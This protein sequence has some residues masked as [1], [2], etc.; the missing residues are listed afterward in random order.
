M[1]VYFLILAVVFGCS[2]V[3]GSMYRRGGLSSII[4][5][6]SHAGL[7]PGYGGHDNAYDANHHQMPG[8]GASGLRNDM[9]N[10]H[11]AHATH[12]A[13]VHGHSDHAYTPHCTCSPGETC[14]TDSHG[15][16][17]CAPIHLHAYPSA[18]GSGRGAQCMY[19][20]YPTHCI[21]PLIRGIVSRATFQ[22]GRCQPIIS[23]GVSPLCIPRG[24]GNNIFPNIGSCERACLY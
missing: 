16:T 4:A 1:A 9:Y 17:Y 15:K 7:N 6:A 8:Y 20:N 5:R 23:S 10:T 14:R 3:S 13:N 24:V 22:N 18:I 2:Q 19:L 11:S 21:R 12:T